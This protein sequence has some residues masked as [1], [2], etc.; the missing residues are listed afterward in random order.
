VNVLVNINDSESN[1][2]ICKVVVFVFLYTVIV[3]KI[4]VDD[5]HL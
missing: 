3:P 4:D 2:Y 1:R 5:W